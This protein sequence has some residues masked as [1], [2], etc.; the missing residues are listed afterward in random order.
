MRQHWFHH[1]VGLA[2][3]HRDRNCSL[4]HVYVD[5]QQPKL[6]DIVFVSRSQ[7]SGADGLCGNGADCLLWRAQS[8]RKHTS[9]CWSGGHVERGRVCACRVCVSFRCASNNSTTN[10][11]A[12]ITSPNSP[13]SA[14]TGLTGSATFTWTVTR[15][16]C[17]T[18]TATVTHQQ[19]LLTSVA[20][21]NQNL[22]CVQSTTLSANAPVAFGATGTWNKLPGG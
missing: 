7:P 1:D 6:R 10:S 20:G 18:R 21:T 17:T 5:T 12:S 16:G 8:C 4:R 9:S 2:Y 13:S 3:F 15:A 22:G 11:A 14:V 19:Q